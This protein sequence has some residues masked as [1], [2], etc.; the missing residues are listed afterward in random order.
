MKDTLGLTWI[1]GWGGWDN[2]PSALETNA[3]GLKVMSIRDK[4][5]TYSKAQ[6]MIWEAEN[7]QW[8]PE[9]RYM[10]NYFET[11]ETGDQFPPPPSDPDSRIAVQ[12]THQPGYMVRNPWPN[13]EYHYDRIYYVATFRMKILKSTPN[14]DTVAVLS[15]YCPTHGNLGTPRVLHDSSFAVS[16]TY[17]EFKVPFSLQV[18]CNPPCP[19]GP[20]YLTGGA[21]ALPSHIVCTNVDIRVWWAG[22]R[23]TWLDWVLVDDLE[24]DSLFA[25]IHNQDLRKEIDDYDALNNVQRVYLTDEPP[26]PGWLPHEQIKRFIHDSVLT[27]AK[28][29]ITASPWTDEWVRRFSQDAQPDT[30]LYVNGA[31]IYFYDKDI[32]KLK[33]LGIIP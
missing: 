2:N 6:R 8:P 7:S 14:T 18:T 20:A 5:Y 26:I 32:T 15:L 21:S 4:A 33:A 16:D 9:Q 29:A 24:A 17:Y 10:Y 1:Q 27:T 31:T 3:K 19:D 11:K 30:I 23:T 12:G 13:Y 28:P 22:H 25:G